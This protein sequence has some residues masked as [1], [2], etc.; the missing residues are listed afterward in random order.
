M[1]KRQ[2]K[3]EFKK[4]YGCNPDE[5]CCTLDI[6]LKNMSK[7]CDEI[8]EAMPKIL[9]DIAESLNTLNQFLASDGFYHIVQ[10]L[11]EMELETKNKEELKGENNGRI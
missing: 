1:N 5:F 7:V 3:K 8:C 2:A 6:C 4:K 10:A 9:E 11:S